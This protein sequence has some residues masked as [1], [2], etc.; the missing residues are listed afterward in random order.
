MKSKT[1]A[2][3]LWLFLGLIGGHKFYLNKP[4]MGVLYLLTCGLFFVGWF[5][6][7]FTLGRQVDQY[8]HPE[9]Y[10]SP[11]PYRSASPSPKIPSP[12]EINDRHRELGI[13]P[14]RVFHIV[15]EDANGNVT[16]RDIEILK[17]SE[18][19][20]DLY[21]HAFCHLRLE[22]RRFLE[23]RIIAISVGGQPIEDIKVYLNQD[24]NPP[25]AE[26]LAKLALDI[27]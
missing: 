20:D 11:A 3:L 6:D 9:N 12:E 19:G 1:T 5:I 21:I 14:G 26:D 16:E 2:Y 22:V 24:F 18:R 10:P 23:S 8:N 25:S 13:P 17:I 15:Y 27:D 4:G 7:L